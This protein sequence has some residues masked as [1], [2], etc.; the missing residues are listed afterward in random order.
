[1][2]PVV[3]TKLPVKYRP[4]PV[5]KR[6]CSVP[7]TNPLAANTM[8]PYVPS[9]VARTRLPPV[10]AGA[11]TKMYPSPALV[12]PNAGSLNPELAIPMSM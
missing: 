12:I 5:L 1:M 2:T 4:S 11:L 10:P 9:A 7:D 8:S 3:A 6:P